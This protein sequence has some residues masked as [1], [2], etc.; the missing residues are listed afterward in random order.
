MGGLG[1]RRPGVQAL[2]GGRRSGDEQTDTTQS[3]GTMACHL[4]GPLAMQGFLKPFIY[5]GKFTREGKR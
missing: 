1:H 5:F 2:E 3:A 4:G